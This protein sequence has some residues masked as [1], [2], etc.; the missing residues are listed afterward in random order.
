MIFLK[1]LISIA[2]SLSNYDLLCDTLI[3][4]GRVR[5]SPFVFHDRFNQVIKTNSYDI[6][7][8]VQLHGYD[9]TKTVTNLY[10]HIYIIYPNYQAKQ[11]Y[12]RRYIMTGVKQVFIA[13]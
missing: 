3:S 11:L 12:L 1:K 7:W 6:I 4:S 8:Y 10:M 9:V 2:F 13:Y 5:K